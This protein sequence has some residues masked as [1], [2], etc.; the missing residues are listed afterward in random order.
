MSVI[1]ISGLSGFFIALIYFFLIHKSFLMANAKN[2]FLYSWIFRYGLVVSVLLI[3]HL[4]RVLLIFWWGLGF[5]V[6]ALYLMKYIGR[7]T[8]ESDIK[9]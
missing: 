9:L 1:F 3:L 4:F 6:G 5:C 8:D 2:N 7:M